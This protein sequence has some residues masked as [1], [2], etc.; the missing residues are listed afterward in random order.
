MQVV[1]SRALFTDHL[2]APDKFT[3]ATF[4]RRDS[5]RVVTSPAAQKF[6]TVDPVGRYVTLPTGR[7]EGPP[8]RIILAIIRRILVV[9]QIRRGRQFEVLEL[10]LQGLDVGVRI[11]PRDNAHLRRAVVSYLEDVT[12]G[13]EVLHLPPTG[14]DLTAARD[15]VTFAA[16]LHVV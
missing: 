5:L 14:L 3:V 2:T 8:L 6:A 11:L 1:D 10:R 13:S 9:H 15:A 16:Q 7:T 12:E 4:H